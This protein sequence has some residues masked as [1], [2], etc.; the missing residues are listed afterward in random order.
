MNPQNA[1]AVSNVYKYHWVAYSRLFL[2]RG[3]LRLDIP[4][5]MSPSLSC[6]YHNRK[7]ASLLSLKGSKNIKLVDFVFGKLVYVLVLYPQCGN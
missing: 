7:K 1:S 3:L 4:L 2:S 6:P 5:A